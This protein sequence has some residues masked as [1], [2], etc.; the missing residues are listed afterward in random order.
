MRVQT[1]AVIILLALPSVTLGQSLGDQDNSGRFEGMPPGTDR[2]HADNEQGAF[3]IPIGPSGADLQSTHR[4]ASPC[5]V[6]DHNVTKGS[7]SKRSNVA[8]N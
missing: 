2:F 5:Q 4:F 7:R 1:F 8:C 3:T 6:G